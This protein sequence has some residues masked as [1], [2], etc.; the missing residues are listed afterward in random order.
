M[1]NIERDFWNHGVV[2]TA[3][4]AG[5]QRNPANVAAHNFHDQDAVVG[6]G[7]GVKPVDSIGRNGHGRIKTEGVVSRIDVIVNGLRNTNN[8]NAV[9]S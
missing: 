9:V 6:L 8:R 4:H 7:G 1:G 3:R 5:V 2:R